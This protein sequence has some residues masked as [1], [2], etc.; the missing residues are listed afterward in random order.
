MSD[1]TPTTIVN[2][3]VSNPAPVEADEPEVEKQEQQVASVSTAAD[4]AVAA[5]AVKTALGVGTVEALSDAPAEAPK[6]K[7]GRPLGSKNKPKLS[8]SEGK[9]KGAKKT[10][11]VVAKKA[12]AKSAKKVT[13][14]TKAVAKAIPTPKKSNKEAT[15]GQ[16]GPSIELDFEDLNDKEIKVMKV[17]PLEGERGILTIPALAKGAWPTN[18]QGKSNSWTRNCLRRLVRGNLIEK[19]KRGEYRISVKG[20]HRMEK[21]AKA[22]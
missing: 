14:A 16:S 6:K 19:L 11:K 3:T 5:L 17:F 7:R 4:L 20:R 22:T 10:K 9:A 15:S 2:P 12:S 21:A 13:K 1:P 18:T 8:A